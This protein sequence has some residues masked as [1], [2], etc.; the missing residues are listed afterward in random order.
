LFFIA[1]VVCL[2]LASVM[3]AMLVLDHLGGLS[4]P[5]CGPGSEC[6][7]AAASV[8]GKVPYI[9]W[10]VSFLGLAYFLGALIAWLA[11]RQGV[12]AAF[13]WLVRL[14]AL[15]SFGF[16]LVIIFGGYAC[17]YCLAAHAGNFGFWACVEL[18]RGISTASLRP[19]TTTIAV[20]VAASIVL[21]IVDA[22]E[23][24]IA[25]RKQ[26]ALLAESTSQIIGASA[27]T[28]TP[29]G[30]G[31]SAPTTAPAGAEPVF[32]GRYRVGP[33]EAAIRIVMFTDYQ[34]EDCY[35]IEQQLVQLYNTRK[36]LSVSIKHF[37]FNS[38]CNPGL[39]STLHGNACWAARAA[40]AA[41][42][43]W[44]PEGFWKMH[45]WLFNQKGRFE[46]T[47]AL[48]NGI[49]EIGYDPKGFIQAMTSDEPL[50]L[51]KA[52]VAEA[53]RLGLYFT[54]MIFINGVELKGWTAPNALLR[55]VEQVAATN[56]PARSAA[57][58]HPPAA[59]EKYVDDWRVQ[60]LLMLPPDKQAW[61]LGPA[62]AKVKIV[63]WGDYQEEGCTQADAI[64]RAFAK[65]RTDLQYTYRHYPFNS[66]CNPRLKEQRFPNSCRAAKAAEA[67]GRLGGNDGYWKMHGWLMENREKFSDA[68]LRAAATQMGFDAD[69]LLAAMEQPELQAN[70]VDDIEAAKQLPQLRHGLPPGLY[71]IP[72]IFVNGR[73]IPRWQLDD[74]PVLKDILLEAGK[75]GVVRADHPGGTEPSRAGGA[76][77]HLP[78]AG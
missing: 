13:R 63:M 6:A 39:G 18:S 3:S 12:P 17:K 20:F 8:W 45:V 40:E 24:R 59:F 36:D 1:G 66:D 71:G 77:R 14:G 34:C 58:D 42:K 41:G 31:A 26:E 51:I 32:T 2:L 21:G 23:K 56:P 64:I 30:K 38:E 54:P 29:P 46:T 50:E 28:A 61:T 10:P 78:A 60:P 57:F 19:I 9:N 47:A 15:A 22:R 27:Q 62:D 75:W 72:T 7:K 67:A 73:Y 44:G 43:L 65:G 69:A 48:E 4:L 25:E 16:I 11:S 52:D 49:R 33:A 53:K 37:P 74:K 35:K 55:A 70:I 68:A 76:E 5:G